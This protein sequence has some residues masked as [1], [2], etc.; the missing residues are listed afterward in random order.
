[1]TVNSSKNGASTHIE[2]IWPPLRVTKDHPYPKDKPVYCVRMTLESPCNSFE[3]VTRKGHNI[4]SIIT[5]YFSQ[6]PAF[7]VLPEEVRQYILPA[8]G[9]KLLIS[10][11]VKGG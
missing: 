2:L 10:C 4:R 8:K 3:K 6:L 11:S 1:M 5:K 7:N 9:N